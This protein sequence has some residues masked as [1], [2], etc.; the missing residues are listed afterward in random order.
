MQTITNKRRLLLPM[1]KALADANRL[2]MLGW[3]SQREHSVQELASL[4]GLK[5]PTV[6]HHLSKLR[7][8]GLVNLRQ[9]GN[10]RYYRV[11]QPRLDQFKAMVNNIEQLPA[12]AEEAD[13]AW[14]DALNVSEDDRKVLHTYTLNG[15][16]QRIPSKEKKLLSVLRW[17]ETKFEADTFYDEKDVNNILSEVHDD[18]ATLRRDLVDFGFLRRER[19][20]GKYWLTPENEPAI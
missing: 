8:V 11:N 5:E 13:E 19:G 17:L 10:Y 16:L 20:G 4:A 7:E 9:D 3:L 6:S 15:R 14:I 12:K 2:N 1:L 18:Y